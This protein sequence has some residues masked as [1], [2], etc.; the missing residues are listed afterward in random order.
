V[1]GEFTLVT[2]KSYPSKKPYHPNGTTSE[3]WAYLDRGGNEVATAHC[4]VHSIGPVSPP[5]PKTV[6]IG[7]LRYTIHATQIMANPELR[8]PFVWMRKCYG[9]VQRNIIC[10][11]FGPIAVLP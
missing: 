11:F 2:M 6:K 5:D 1:A 3:L 7:D 4:Y 10:P 9:W 8:L